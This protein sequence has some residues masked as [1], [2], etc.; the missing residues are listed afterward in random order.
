MRK[1][2]FFLGCLALGLTLGCAKQNAQSFDPSP[3]LGAD[4]GFST[5]NSCHPDSPAIN[6]KNIPQN[7]T[8]MDAQMLDLD[9]GVV[10]GNAQLGIKTTGHGM[11]FT[12]ENGVIPDTQIIG[13]Q[14]TIPKGALKDYKPPCPKEATRNYQLNVRALDAKDGELARVST[15]RSVNP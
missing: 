4:F 1:S 7:A 10:I 6:L 3:G 15:T 12:N 9:L 11:Y 5:E 2:L 14:G 13:Q 8:R